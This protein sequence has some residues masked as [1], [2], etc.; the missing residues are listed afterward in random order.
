MLNLFHYPI[1]ALKLTNNMLICCDIHVKTR[2]IYKKYISLYSSERTLKGQNR[3]K[4]KLTL[5]LK[6]I[7]LNSKNQ[8]S[9]NT[10]TSLSLQNWLFWLSFL[11]NN[12]ILLWPSIRNSSII[13]NL[14]MISIQYYR[15][16]NKKSIM[17]N[18]K[19]LSFFNPK[20]TSWIGMCL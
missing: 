11:L 12:I 9:Y 17:M 7:L 4:S 8:T 15:Q 3:R 19:K 20:M 10:V 6:R 18:K 1:L 16:L 2:L 14:N 5:A 13:E